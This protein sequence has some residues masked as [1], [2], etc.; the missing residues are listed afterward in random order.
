[1]QEP[2][3]FSGTAAG[4]PEVT[5]A[6]LEAERLKVEAALLEAERRAA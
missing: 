6:Q 4:A 3:R 5:L 2:K 1:M